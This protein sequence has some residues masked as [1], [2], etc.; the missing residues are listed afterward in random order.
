MNLEYF[1]PATAAWFRR[2]FAAPTEA[3]AQ[4]WPAI[5]ARQ[6]TLIAA[7]TGSG[8]TL[9]AFLAAIDALVREGLER[10]LGNECQVLYVSPLKALSN[11]IHKNLQQPLEGIREEL[12]AQNFPD[13]EV[14]ALVRT[15]D[16]PQSER[17]RMRREPPHI[18]VTTPES[19]YI[20]LTSDSG[21]RILS[22]VKSVI[23]DEIHALAGNKRGAHLALSLERLA[24]LT[25]A[26]PVRVGLSATQ[27]PIEEVARFLTGAE[28]DCSIIDTGHIRERRLHL[29]MPRSPLAPVMA[30]EVWAEIYD[31]LSELIGTHRTTLVFTN[32]RRQAER[33]ARHLAER[34]G[35][36]HVTS[37]HGSL[38]RAHRL[39]AEQRL[40]RGELKALVATSSLE[41]GLD[42]G[43]VDLVCQLG[44]PRSIG[45]FLQRVGR[46]GHALGA[47]PEG[48]L[49]PL[50]RDDLVEC[51]ALLDS[52]RRGEL[53]ALRV[54]N[55]PLDVLAQQIVGEVACREWGEAELCDA[56]RR[57]WPYRD[58]SHAD[59]TDVVKMLA[60]GFAT[61][62]GRRS[63]YLH[64]DQVN[65]KLRGRRGA[66][67]V[68]VTNGGAIPDQFD[69]EVILSPSGLRI[70]S[71]NEDFSFES[72][73]GDIFQLGN[74]S[75]RILKVETGRVL[76]ED[77]K[78]QP[79]NIPFWFGEAPAR[80]AELSLAVSRLREKADALLR[81]EPSALFKSPLP[82]FM[83]GE[84]VGEGGSSKHPAFAPAPSPGGRGE[85]TAALEQ[86]FRDELQLPIAAAQQL[87]E[88]LATARAALS[89][90]PTQDRVVFERFFDEAGDQHFVIHSPFGARINRAWGL[91]LRKRFCRKFNFELQAAA[92]ED[93]IVLSLGVTHSFPLE[94]PARY[95]SSATALDVLQQAVLA[96]PMF[97]T[98]WR[99]VASTAL[100]VRRNRNG[101]RT[102]PAFQRADAQ[103]LTAVVFPDQL[104]CAENLTGAIEI[105]DHPLVRQTLNDCLHE[106]M[107]ADG[108]LA[109]LRRLES[110][111][112]KVMA[113]DLAAPSPLAQE[114]LTAR[115][116]AFLDDAPA[117]ERRTLAVQSRGVMSLE[118]AGSLA[119]LDP[120]AIARVRAE[121]WP[122]ARDADELHDALTVLGFITEQEGTSAAPDSLSPLPPGEG[123]RRAG[124]GGGATDLSSGRSHLF[125]QLIATKRATRLRL[126][127]GGS[128]SSVT[129]AKTGDQGFELSDSAAKVG[130]VVPTAIALNRG[131][132]RHSHT[133]L[134][135]AA[136]RLPE[137]LAVYPDVQLDPTIEPVAESDSEPLSREDA[138][139]ELLRSRLEVSGPVTVAALT[140]LFALPANE[141]EPALLALEAEGSVMRGQ[142]NPQVPLPPLPP[143]EGWGEGANTR[144]AQNEWCERR[145]LA[146]IHH[147][148]LKRLR[149]EIEPVTPAD[150]LRF[151]FEWQ[152]VVGER[153]EGQ[154]ALAAV[155]EQLEGF[156]APAAS[157]EADILPARVGDYAPY[158]LDQLCAGGSI[159]WLRLSAPRVNADEHHAGPVRNT[160]IA[161]VSRE[162][163]PHWRALASLPDDGTLNLSHGARAVHDALKHRGA[164]F[165]TDL[166]NETGLLR[167]QL[168]AALAEL[169]ACGLATADSFA[170]LRALIAPAAKRAPLA[171]SFRYRLRRGGPPGV[172]E[173]GRWSL[174]PA[175]AVTGDAP[176]DGEALAHLAEVL[177][178]RYGV[179][180]RKVLERESGLPP[181][182]ELLYIYRRLEARGEVRGGRFVDGFAGE[183]FAL[184]EA[185]GAL[186]DTRR[187]EKTGELVSVS[188]AD[189]LNLVGIVTPG[190]RVPVQGENR[191]LYRDGVPVAVQVA[192]EVKFIE[193]VAPGAEWLLRNSLLRRQPP[194]AS[195][196]H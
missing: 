84:G 89:V 182:R 58:L 90:L 104:A 45:T 67:L 35:E 116:F 56:F 180:F 193:S 50:S 125:E 194:M 102:P 39:D 94:E 192:E 52:V 165:F 53:D 49:F 83:G 173:A 11:D 20:L 126:N 62:R 26:P 5:R 123:A 191:V 81:G 98:R 86:W 115:P 166:V 134:W 79:P 124:E 129:P 70:G 19:L 47:L 85:A 177:L 60:E 21:R 27:K 111:E 109:L 122:E 112:L 176:A 30:N 189:P 24:A 93:T 118:E 46:S 54:P 100:A 88:Y 188:A 181:W 138:L 147:Y 107:D 91:A 99:W 48:R 12:R 97:G 113:R 136:E 149:S 75:Y 164:L 183:Q 190:A 57:A 140:E 72:I 73:P 171:R 74:T 29:E 119:A 144:P 37:H 162:A 41:L 175:R 42:I 33:V 154:A 32:N 186:R 195:G 65:G 157:W 34:I 61:R 130:A 108:F 117:E 66:K 169:T 69:Y 178:R 159:A 161:F 187:R 167:T 120:E 196:I 68:A 145:L 168:E 131:G 44:S 28:Q 151:L 150:Y 82:P 25:P 142:F 172:N 51:T 63:A 127:D 133:V 137:L 174:V 135:A 170:G 2:S 105:P 15:G 95:L 155:L 101:R 40:K 96:A 78:G 64:R 36:Q 55:A 114:I 17:E 7:P 10:G 92:L 184:P 23:V 4:A 143:G 160:P 121:V 153:A 148:T 179:V 152:G 22:T 38:A 128:N 139:R 110:G 3:Q 103:D 13:V 106:V 185:V 71:L 31:R 8:K 156:S 43:D 80:S 132:N 14:R 6:H 87:A 163:L 141:I 59:Y 76:V 1:H 18:L 77:A 158:Q 16:T 9:A 146:R